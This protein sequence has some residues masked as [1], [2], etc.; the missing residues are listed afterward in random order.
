MPEVQLGAVTG[1]STQLQGYL[2]RPSGTGPWPGVV[3]LHEAWGVDDVLRRQ[4]DRLAAAGYL[5]LGPDLYSDGG[6]PRCIVTT[7]LALSRGQGKALAD[8]EASRQWLLA[9]GD[10]TG[11]IGVIGFCLGGG[12]ALVTST[13]GFDAASA[14][15]GPVPKHAEQALAGACP[16]IGSYGAKDLL[17]RGMAPTLTRALATIGVTYDV[18]EYPTAGHSFLNDEPNGPRV[19][20]P[21]LRIAHIGPDPVAASDAWARIEAFFAA[22]LGN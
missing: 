1:G 6:L 22:H 10:C 12:F 5:A 9:Q 15:Y 4:V 19:L 2:A 18:K 16:I 7:F 3:A 14:N 11:K 20:R 21:L 17:M 8:I 13:R